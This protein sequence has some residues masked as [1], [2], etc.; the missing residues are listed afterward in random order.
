LTSSPSCPPRPVSPFPARV[1]MDEHVEFL[2]LAEEDTLPTQARSALAA[3][4]L[5]A[6]G[7]RVARER[8]LLAALARD[9]RP[10]LC[11]VEDRAS[12]SGAP[13]W[14][15]LAAAAAPNTLLVFVCDP[16]HEERAL[17]ALEAGLADYLFTGQ[18]L[19]LGPLLRRWLARPDPAGAD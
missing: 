11:L 1:E 16:D 7:R 19:R 3:A 17:A 10:A 18:L 8:E 13:F 4:G 14:R 6:S 5:H 12:P 9:G 2:V 15:D